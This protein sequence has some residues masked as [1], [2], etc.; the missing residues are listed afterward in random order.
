V[1]VLRTAR[2]NRE[3]CLNIMHGTAYSS[4]CVRGVILIGLPHMLLETQSRTQ[5]KTSMQLNRCEL[6][7]TRFMRV[8]KIAKRDWLRHVCPSAWNNSASTGRSFMKFDV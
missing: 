4:G 5:R 8:R 1:F 3:R 2:S 7:K 6:L